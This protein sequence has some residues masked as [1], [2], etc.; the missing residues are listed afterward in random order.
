M[1][2]KKAK[3]QIESMMRNHG[4]S[5]REAVMN[6]RIN[7]EVPLYKIIPTLLDMLHADPDDV[8][9]Q[10][11]AVNM[12]Q[13]LS[14]HDTVMNKSIQDAMIKSLDDTIALSLYYEQAKKQM[15]ED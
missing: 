8:D 12:L 5:A 10:L 6:T 13:K 2:N 3:K 9:E 11:K 7:V 14:E 4:I 15:Y 1:Y